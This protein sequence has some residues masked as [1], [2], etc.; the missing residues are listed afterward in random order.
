VGKADFHIHT[1]LNDGTATVREV[2]DYVRDRTDLDV[3]AITDHDRLTGSYQ[4]LEIANEYRF[5]V[6]SGCEIT[7]LHGHL[8]ALF[9]DKPI[10]MWRPLDWTIGK[11][12]EQGGLA[13]VPHPFSRNRRRHLRH[14][15]LERVAPTLDIVEVFNAREVAS[16]SNLRAL[17]FAR[18]HSLPGG[19]GSDSHRPIEI[20]RAYVDV[21]P[22]VTPQEL[23]VA[24]RDGKVTGTLSGLGIHVRTW[25][26]IGRKFMRTRVARLR[27]NAR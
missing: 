24:L 25:V 5:E 10:P 12:H 6:V 18:Q 16:A 11:I 13:Y 4:A 23:V 22:F 2:L 7:T 21:V 3:M 14:S 26:D 19:V 15:V 17:E 27:S 9:I 8:L 20:G 1:S